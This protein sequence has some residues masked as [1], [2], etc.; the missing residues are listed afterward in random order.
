MQCWWSDGWRIK[1]FNLSKK[2][3]IIDSKLIQK[4]TNS[5]YFGMFEFWSI[6][7]TNENQRKLLNEFMGMTQRGT[8]D[9]PRL[10][11]LTTE[12]TIWTRQKITSVTSVSH[13]FHNT[14]CLKQER[15]FP[16]FAQTMNL[17][18][19]RL[20]FIMELIPSWNVP[21]GQRVFRFH[22]N[23]NPCRHASFDE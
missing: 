8:Q 6:I 21:R 11:S 4:L 22:K 20:R 13:P 10:I 19:Q 12:R 17:N 15:M 2:W 18:Q 23:K 9:C 5:S 3:I 16:F 14:K 1:F 7:R